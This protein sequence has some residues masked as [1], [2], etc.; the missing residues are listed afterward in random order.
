MIRESK[1]VR[2]L[3]ALFAISM[4]AAS[5]GGSDSEGS[6][7]D[8]GGDTTTTA[9]DDGGTETTE[10]GDDAAPST[11]GGEFVDL[12]T[13]VG[14][15][16]EH[17]DPALN[18]TLDAYQVI[19]AVYDGLT[20]IDASD[21]LN[22]QFV[23]LVA[24][25][26]TPNDDASVWTFHIRE[27]AAFSNGDEINASTFQKSWERAADLAGDYSYLITFIDGGAERLA[28][29]ADTISGVEADDA[30]RTL[31]RHPRRAVLDLRRGGRLPAVLP[32]A[33]RRH[34]GRRGLGERHHDRQRSLRH[35]IAPHR[36]GDRP[37]QERQLGR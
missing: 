17:I 25:E 24:D 23:P 31:D 35:G 3:A 13:F 22:P 26:V 9:A 36:R 4:V 37:G 30:T 18:S 19:N 7:T 11:G 5:C 14:D 15:P 8:D 12:G 32:R 1:L 10:G 27:G 21:P 6:S 28:G 29:E 16:P 20:E 2:L 34:R 33:R